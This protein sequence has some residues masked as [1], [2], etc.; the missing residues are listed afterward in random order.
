MNT[1]ITIALL[2]AGLCISAVFGFCRF[3]VLL[4]SKMAEAQASEYPVTLDGTNVS[5]F[6]VKYDV[7]SAN[8][9][10]STG[11]NSFRAAGSTVF[12]SADVGKDVIIY[13]RGN[14]PTKR[15]MKGNVWTGC[16]GRV[17][18]PSAIA[19]GSWV[20]NSCV[21]GAASL[22]ASTDT[23][24]ILYGTDNTAALQ[25][26]VDHGGDNILD[27][28]GSVM[29]KDSILFYHKTGRFEGLGPE[30]DLTAPT[31]SGSNIIW[32]G[33]ARIPMFKLRADVLMTITNVHLVGNGNPAHRPSAFFDL[34]QELKPPYSGLQSMDSL[35]N[36]SNDPAGQLGQGPFAD[37]GVYFEDQKPEN[38]VH[39]FYSLR[40]F[41][42]ASAC[43]D[44]ENQ[45]SIAMD[46]RDFYCANTP[47]AWY[48][49]HGGQEVFTGV[50]T[51]SNVG[52]VFH[53]GR[54]NRAAVDDLEVTNTSRAEGGYSQLAYF[55]NNRFSAGGGQL[56]VY[57]GRYE[58]SSNIP[59][60]VV[61]LLG[62]VL[63]PYAVID[64]DNPT[65]SVVDLQNFS[66]V[67]SPSLPPLNASWFINLTPNPN[68]NAIY[69]RCY[70]CSG[71][72]PQSL[73]RIKSGTNPASM[74]IIEIRQL[75]PIAIYTRQLLTRGAR[76]MPSLETLHPF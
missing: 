51:A 23:Y 22:A 46:F 19:I 13:Y 29:I 68:L 43:I 55:E 66:F 60:H 40:L 73:S 64:T 24:V 75:A 39:M 2:G 3:S 26:A 5:A 62:H 27:L 70:Q 76:F 45:Q 42:L 48:A 1:K 16:I 36:V 52:Q 28:K 32:A 11:S 63:T 35:I 10:I 65:V 59:T 21:P 49:P 44:D 53:Q 15:F 58:I 67:N 12:S 50:F 34:A 47:V 7:K 9:M 33:P 25:S 17:N 57:K 71:L 38:D 20:G 6:G 14:G 18:S 56:I 61:P 72:T 30:G 37:A 69:F 31:P 4:N 41:N 8:G 54:S 74:D